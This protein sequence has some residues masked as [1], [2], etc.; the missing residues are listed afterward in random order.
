MISG[1]H[2]DL[3][4]IQMSSTVLEDESAKVTRL[5][6][7]DEVIVGRPMTKDVE[8]HVLCA[9]L[10][11]VERFKPVLSPQTCCNLASR[12]EIGCIRLNPDL[13]CKEELQI[14]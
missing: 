12:K 11:P 3:V 9:C 13:G 4:L 2:G 14:D 1:E 6:A 8:T 7:V 5:G 10:R